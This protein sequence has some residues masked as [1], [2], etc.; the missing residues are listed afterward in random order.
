MWSGKTGVIW[1]GGSTFPGFGNIWKVISLLK[2][3]LLGSC[4]RVGEF[5]DTKDGGQESCK[6]EGE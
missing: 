1:L 6:G 4:A 3:G 2:A 5:T